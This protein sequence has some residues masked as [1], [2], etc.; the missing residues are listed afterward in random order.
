[1]SLQIEKTTFSGVLKLTPIIHLD[2]RGCFSETYRE[3]LLTK[4]GFH[5]T[6]I[7]DNQSFSKDAYTLRG[8][9]FQNTPHAQDK[10][11][12]V[13]HGEILDVIVD[14]RE[15]SPTF[16]KHL[17][18]LL[19]AKNSRQLLIPQGFAHGFLTLTPETVVCYKVTHYYQPEAELGI[20]WNDPDLN[21]DWNIPKNTSPIISNKDQHLPQLKELPKNLFPAEN[22]HF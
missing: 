14:L 18:T 13:I 17:T 6:F 16:G 7:Q 3:D 4:A 9:H 19:S 10:L 11:V 20:Y 21:I 15:T 5:K 22:P 8:L 2:E 1:M 12:R